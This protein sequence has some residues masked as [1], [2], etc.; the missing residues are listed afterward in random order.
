MPKRETPITIGVASPT[1]ARPIERRVWPGQV[2]PLFDVP[3]Q[4]TTRGQIFVCSSGRLP[5]RD[6][7]ATYLIFDRVLEFVI[8][9]R[10]FL[11]ECFR[12]IRPGGT[13]AGFVPNASG[14]GQVDIVNAARYV[15]DIIKRGPPL[16]EISES[17]WRKHFTCREMQV[18]LTN[19][20]FR[21]MSISS[22]GTLRREAATARRLISRTIS[23]EPRE[24]LFDPDF[25]E[26]ES[27]NPAAGRV[28]NWR[29]AVLSFE[30]LRP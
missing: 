22:R 6:C 1:M 16:P 27:V 8:D 21:S 4:V 15:N 17:G 3:L 29:G 24:R 26:H 11:D 9:E 14:F 30:A 19:S 2:V 13:L 20:G 10:R 12:V 7:A 5:L 28:R 25:T 18:L 23:Q